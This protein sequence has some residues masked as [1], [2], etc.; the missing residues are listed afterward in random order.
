MSADPG[1][2]L[3]TAEV[4]DILRLDRK[5]IL[6]L[7]GDGELDAINVARSGRPKLRIPR[8]SLDAYTAARVIVRA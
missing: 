5:T 2:Y 1:G 7:I 6:R 3:S 4:A 8:T